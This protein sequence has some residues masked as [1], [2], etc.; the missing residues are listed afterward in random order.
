VATIWFDRVKACVGW[1]PTDCER[2]TRLRDYL[3]SDL[4][5]IIAILGEQLAQL[6]G[7]QSLM[8]NARFVRRLHSVLREWLTGL[9]NGTFDED[10]IRARWEFGQRMVEADL[11]FE[12]VILLEG[13]ARKQFAELAKKRSNGRSRALSAMLRT[14]EKALCLDLALVHGSYL[15]VHDARM[16]Q[17]LLD[18]FLTITGFSRTLYENL[19]ETRGRNGGGEQ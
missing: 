12:D 14:L 2:I 13:L 17:V 15:Q 9:L 4:D 19:A 10:Y 3:D 16:E 18:R 1:S 7:T 8:A 6:K 11:T 5:G